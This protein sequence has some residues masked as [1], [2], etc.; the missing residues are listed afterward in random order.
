M[1]TSHSKGPRAACVEDFDED[2]NTVVSQSRVVAAKDGSDSGYS[3]RTGTVDGENPGSGKMAAVRSIERD[4]QPYS[5]GPVANRRDSVNNQMPVRSKVSERPTNV[6]ES[7]TPFRHD[8]G[9]CYTCDR[10]GEHVTQEELDQIQRREDARRNAPA[11]KPRPV[12]QS[13]GTPIQTRP[14]ESLLRRMSSHRES[15]PAPLLPPT[16]V[17]VLAGYINQP[18]FQ[19]ATISTPNGHAQSPYYTTPATPGSHGYSGGAPQHDYIQTVPMIE[20]PNPTRR[21]QAYT[22]PDR[23]SARSRNS[24]HQ[25]K[26]SIQDLRQDLNREQRSRRESDDRAAVDRE[27]MPPP[28]L[29]TKQV[30]PARR[31]SVRKSYTTDEPRSVQSRYRVDDNEYAV[32]EDGEYPENRYHHHDSPPRSSNPQR[33]SGAPVATRPPARQ[34]VSYSDPRSQAVK[35]ISKTRT[36]DDVVQ[37][38]AT[39]PVVPADDKLTA[40]E[41]KLAAQEARA[42]AYQSKR[43]SMTSHELSAEKLKSMNATR[44]PSR[45]DAGSHHG[46]HYS[47]HSTTSKAR[48]ESQSIVIEAPKSRPLSIDINGFKL[49]IDA[50]PE[51]KESKRREQRAIE[52]APASSTGY[53]SASRSRAATSSHASSDH[54]RDRDY[55]HESLKRISTSDRRPPS[56]PVKVSSKSSKHSSRAPSRSRAASD[57]ES[58]RRRR[59]S[60]SGSERYVY[61]G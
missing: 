37:R 10:F 59:E 32:V 42:E 41:E 55:H 36:H 27:M 9:K 38:R 7:R 16:S 34:S 13:S 4:R 28:R 57:V 3:S 17:P 60:V 48:R 31:P 20:K 18:M 22:D 30:A 52:A 56:S 26:A 43:Q 51:K 14:D 6:K 61:G 46:S 1:P 45:S 49:K 53:S 47:K 2:K 12:R 19:Y 39:A 24:Y 25:S 35:T 15:R 40:Q 21:T 54:S 23:P 29:P 8:P 58:S 44:T 5:S 50:E 11:E 33:A